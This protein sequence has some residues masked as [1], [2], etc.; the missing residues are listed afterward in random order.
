M[1]GFP[2]LSVL[3][4][5]PMIAAI[6]CLFV[7]ANMARMLALAATLIDFVLGIMLWMNFDIGGAQWQFVEHAPGIFGPFGWSL[8][9]D[10][11]A[12]MLIMLSVFLMPICIG[13][14]WRSITPPA[15][16]GRRSM[17][18]APQAVP[19]AHR[20]GPA[21]ARARLTSWAVGGPSWAASASMASGKPQ[22]C[23]CM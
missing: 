12:L 17:P 21:S 1:T 9:I 13:A 18:P 11:F 8:G 15:A 2:I 20:L 5:V 19:L 22:P 16:S 6:A 7:S 23:R 4:A 14:S 3:I 10:G